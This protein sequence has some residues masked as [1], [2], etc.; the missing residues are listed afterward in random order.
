MLHSAVAK[1]ALLAA[2]H[3]PLPL[4]D[5]RLIVLHGAAVGDATLRKLRDLA[6]NARLVSVYGLTE[7][8][9]VSA[10]GEWDG[11]SKDRTC[12]PL[13]ATAPHRRIT[14]HTVRGPARPGVQGTISIEGLGVAV[15]EDDPTGS[16]VLV[17]GD[18]GVLDV[19]G[20]LHT[21]GRAD[22]QY[23]VF[24][25]RVEAAGVEAVLRSVPGIQDSVVVQLAADAPLV[26]AVILAEGA[27]VYDVNRIALGRLEPWE[28]P[29]TFVSLPQ[30][31]LSPNGKV[32]AAALFRELQSTTPAAA[33][34]DDAV[35]S[36]VGPIA[37]AIAGELTEILRLRTADRAAV[38]AQDAFSPPEQT[39]FEILL[40]ADALS[41]NHGWEVSVFDLYQQRSPRALAEH[42]ASAT[43]PGGADDRR[44]DES[45]AAVT[46][47]NA[48]QGEVRIAEF[49]PIR[50]VVTRERRNCGYR[51]RIRS[52]GADS[53]REF[54]D[55]VFLG[56]ESLT[57]LTDA[58]LVAAGV[59]EEMRRH[60][61]YITRRPML[62]DPWGFDSTLFGMT[63]RESAVE[64]RSTGSSSNSRLPPRKT[65]TL[66][67]SVVTTTLAST[68]GVPGM[69]TC[70]A[71]FLPTT[72]CAN[73]SASSAHALPTLGTTSLRLRHTS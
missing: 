35:S 37:D 54:V 30:F 65:R 14:V 33:P 43:L 71:T 52:T 13:T 42:I 38:T 9:Q 26:A 72:E 3:P 24:G 51:S 60:P 1:A 58:D 19:D 2:V 25:N 62:A 46:E 55:H 7:T 32:D 66:I 6:P 31:P 22:R 18:F 20:G 69:T 68:G 36:E 63:P 70:N 73:S 8:S 48:K 47:R 21:L 59:S 50:S 27:T 23:S 61:R 11:E 39:S 56:T 44:N 49:A 45:G 28:R 29:A 64:I 67:S 12:V 41:R 15:G 17:T 10:W 34:T 5:L 16:G 4:P 53:Y 40:L 57:D